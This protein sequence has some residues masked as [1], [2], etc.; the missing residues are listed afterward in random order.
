MARVFA[1]L[2]QTAGCIRVSGYKLK[3]LL[4]LKYVIVF[5]KQYMRSVA[6]QTYNGT[7]IESGYTIYTGSSG[8][9]PGLS[10]FEIIINSSSKM[11][12]P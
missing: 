7:R 10:V 5:K 1:V 11:Q 9:Y 3:K 2:L 12:K 6:L 8:G 4:I